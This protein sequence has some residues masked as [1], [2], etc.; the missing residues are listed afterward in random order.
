[1]HPFASRSGMAV[2]LVL[3][4]TIP[5]LTEAA[6]ASIPKIENANSRWVFKLTPKAFQKNPRVD[7]AVITELTAEGRKVRTPTADNPIYYHAETAGF[8]EEG[9]GDGTR[10][11]PPSTYT[12]MQV[13]LEESLTQ[14]HF[15]RETPD[16]PATI[17]LFYFWGVHSRLNSNVDDIGFRNLLS[18]AKLVGG[19]QFAEELD[20]ALRA[21]VLGN[22]MLWGIADPV[23]QF[24]ERDT[25]HRELMSQI[26]DDVYYVV[27]SAYDG[28]ALA[29]GERRLLW[30]TKMSTS[31][32]GVSLEET[33]PALVIG[34]AGFFG[35]EMKEAEVVAKI[36]DRTGRVEIGEPKVKDYFDGPVHTPEK[37]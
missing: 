12:F 17:A 37:K 13:K 9:H 36:I 15:L 2:S 35:R 8:H 5:C 7:L 30:R 28:A 14:N 23:Y 26:L 19:T 10:K 31:S 3:G 1:M 32:Q 27:V 22:G 33:L 6:A 24:R 18:R 4:L 20:R 29:R 25:L 34:G 16:H 21:S 11:S